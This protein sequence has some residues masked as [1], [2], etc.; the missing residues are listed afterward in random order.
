MAA[1]V[2]TA[3]ERA[4]Q[5]LAER[6]RDRTTTVHTRREFT[7]SRYDFDYKAYRRNKKL[8]EREREQ[9]SNEQES[10]K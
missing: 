4:A 1:R 8:V 9:D 7:G 2:S 6:M 3:Q 10:I 5:A